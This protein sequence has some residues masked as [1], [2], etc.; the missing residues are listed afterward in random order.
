[1]LF[2]SNFFDHRVSSSLAADA[3]AAAAFFVFL[4]RILG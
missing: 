3:T 2:Q 1:M 4:Y